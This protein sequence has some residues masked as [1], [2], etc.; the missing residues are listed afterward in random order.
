MSLPELR[1]YSPGTDFLSFGDRAF[2][3]A[4]EVVVVKAADGASSRG[5]LYS[6]GKEKTAIYLMHPRADMT[7]HYAV[8]DIV[9]NGYAFFVQQGRFAG[10]DSSTVHEPLL[11]DI[12]AGMQFVKSRGVENIVLL[13]NG[14]GAGL[15]CLYHAQSITAA[16]ERL[17]HTPAGD[18]FDLNKLEMPAADGVI[19]L[20]AHLGAGEA[21][22]NGIDPSV[23]DESDPLSCDPELDMYNIKNG[24][25]QPPQPVKYSE[26]FL[27]QYRVAQKFRVA[28]LDAIAWAFIHERRHSESRLNTP[29][30]DKFDYNGQAFVMRRAAKW[31]LMQI[32]RLDADPASVDLS[33][34]PS[35][36]SYGSLMSI[37]PDI[38]NYSMMGT[39]LLS[40]QAWLSSWSARYSRASL[41]D[42]LP[43]VTL[44]SLILGYTGDNSIAPGVAELIYRGS[45]AADKEI[46]VVAGDHFGLPVPSRP[47]Q[48][49]RDAAL[50][51]IIRWLRQR[52]PG[53]K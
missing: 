53:S 38:A 25:N 11:A 6:K 21:L 30:F 24:F 29:V 42:N 23:I 2:S 35:D 32:H 49:G 47:N 1:R 8:P 18:L 14:I 28:R 31:R 19:F 3:A 51:T 7:R 36:R 50:K 26:E 45:P 48:G 33:L 9:E 46:A 16:P 12:A 10:D 40:P 44:P 37:R 41:L 22:Q 4:P 39:K 5:V 20:S 27:A 17:S 43:K 52:F 13:G 15:C 34:A